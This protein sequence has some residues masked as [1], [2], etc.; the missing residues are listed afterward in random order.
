[1]VFILLVTSIRRPAVSCSR[2]L[3]HRKHLVVHNTASN[4]RHPLSVV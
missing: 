4:P 3:D 1:M 2:P